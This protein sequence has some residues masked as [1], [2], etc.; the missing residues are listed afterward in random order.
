MSTSNE[1]EAI[2]M[3]EFRGDFIP[4]QPSCPTRRYSPGANVF[5]ITP[6]QIAES[7]FMWDFL[8]SGNDPDLIESA[9]LWAQAAMDAQDFA[10]DDCSQDEEVED[11]ATSFPH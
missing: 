7:T 2:D 10:V 8:R 11:L 1:L 9:Y 3:I 5:R 6:D 4:K